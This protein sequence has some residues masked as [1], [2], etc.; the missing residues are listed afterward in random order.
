L[1]RLSSIAQGC[2]TVHLLYEH[3]KGARRVKG[4]RMNQGRSQKFVSDGDKTGGL[5]TKVPQWGPGA[6]PW[7]GSGGAPRS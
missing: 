1:T 3:L 5:G 6:E 4:S 7:W 2:A